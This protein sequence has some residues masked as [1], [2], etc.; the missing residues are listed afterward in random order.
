MLVLMP[1]GAG[2]S[3]CFQIPALVRDGIGVVI[4]PLIALMEDQVTTLREL[5]V[6]ASFLNSTLSYQQLQALE[7]EIS[8]GELDLLYMAPERASQE[9][10]YQLLSKVKLSLLAIDEAHCV[11][12]WGHNFRPDYLS[13]GEFADRFPDVS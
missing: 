7:E 5:G 10:T 12:E 1:T 6:R 9:R 4:S 8:S 11:S 3:L 2:K 13:L